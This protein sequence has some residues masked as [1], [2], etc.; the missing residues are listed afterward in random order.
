MPASQLKPKLVAVLSD[1]YSA[2]L[3]GASDLVMIVAPV[4]TADITLSPLT[5][6]AV[7][8]ALIMSPVLN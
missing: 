1:D 3:I 8:V 2:K 6:V 4:P 7:T 5:L